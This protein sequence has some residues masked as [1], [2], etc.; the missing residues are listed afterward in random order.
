MFAS[1][2]EA[3]A[4][5]EERYSAEGETVSLHT[6]IKVRM[7]AGKFPVDRFERPIATDGNADRASCCAS[8]A[9]TARAEVLVESS[10]GRFLLNTAFPDD[11]PFVDRPMR[12]ATSPRSSASSSC[13]TTRRSSPTASTS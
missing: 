9:A 10:L 2:D 12:S 5:Y 11:F 4:A 6:K 7:P 13:S 3:V 8:T 1:L